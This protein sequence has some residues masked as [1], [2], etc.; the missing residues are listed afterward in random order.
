V[1]IV[2]DAAP[3][4]RVL[5]ALLTNIPGVVVAGEAGDVAE[6]I[7]AVRALEPDVMILDLTMPGGSG[8]DVL[9]VAK[10][11]PRP[12][13][14]I[15]FTAFDEPHLRE[16]CQHAGADYFFAKAS[17][18]EELFNTIRSLGDPTGSLTVPVSPATPPQDSR[19]N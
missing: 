17:G 2:D 7:N 13:V 18:T 14:A 6:G 5:A 15:I 8:V 1:L 9:I 16:R 3:V 4:R 12:P 19:R 11:S 10:H